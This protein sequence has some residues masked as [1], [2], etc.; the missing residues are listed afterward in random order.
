MGLFDNV[1]V[2][3]DSKKECRL[4]F[5]YRENNFVSNGRIVFSQEL[6]FMK[7]LSCNGECC[8]GETSQRHYTPFEDVEEGGIENL[9]MSIPKNAKDGQL[10]QAIF[11]PGPKDFETGYVEDW[12]WKLVPYEKS[13]K[14]LSD[15]D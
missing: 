6:R 1:K 12:E 10:F 7:S 3:G 2:A 13:E 9:Q 11:V 8:E 15:A 5:R 14:S 4:I